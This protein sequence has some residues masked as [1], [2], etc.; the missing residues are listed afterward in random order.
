MSFRHENYYVELLG[1]MDIEGV[2]QTPEHYS[3]KDANG[4]ISESRRR[5]WVLD[6]ILSYAHRFGDHYVSASLVYTRDRDYSSSSRMRPLSSNRGTNTPGFTMP[7]RGWSQRTRASA[8]LST[9][10]SGRTS[11]LGWK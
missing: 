4:S 11:N 6:N 1:E 3:L 9:G 5:N 10:S 2:G 8:L 7:R